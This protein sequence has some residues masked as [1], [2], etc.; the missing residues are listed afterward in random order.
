MKKEQ[1]KAV[2]LETIAAIITLVT[3][4]LIVIRFILG[5]IVLDIHGTFRAFKKFMNEYTDK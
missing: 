3:V 2:V 1:I 4:V 5:V